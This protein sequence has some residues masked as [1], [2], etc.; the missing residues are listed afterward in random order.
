MTRG[1][2]LL[3]R[4]R[5]GKPSI[6]RLIIV[7]L[8]G[9]DPRLTDR[10]MAEGR[11]PNFQRL[12]EAGCYSRLGTTFPSVSPVAWSSFATGANPAK[13]NIFDFLDR[14]LRTYLPTLSS[15]HIGSVD[16]FLKI[17]RY[18]L[19][20]GKPELRLLRKSKPFWTILGEQ[21][22]WST[23]LRVPIARTTNMACSC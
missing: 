18:R 7:G 14:D 1:W 4:K 19:P 6:K 2:R 10:F 11:L 12:A 5:A 20:L 21:N 8:D 9:Q 22:I 23:V 13:H 3:R 17:G 16:R 15:T